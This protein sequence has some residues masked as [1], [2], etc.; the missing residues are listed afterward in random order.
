MAKRRRVRVGNPKTCVAYLRVST[1]TE[2]QALGVEAQRRAIQ[3]WADRAGVEIV[4][5]FT[6]EVSG[7]ASLDKR[8]ILLEAMASVA[9]HGA[10]FLVVHRLDR[11][12]REPLTAALA[13]IELKRHGAALACADGAGSG[14][15]PT[16]E[17]IRGILLSVHKFEKAM[18][19]ARIK[20]A[21]AVKKSRGELTGAAP[22][23]MRRA[24]D[25]K[26]LEPDEGEMAAIA[27]IRAL[28]ASGLTMR[29]VQATATKDGLRGRTGQPFTL[30]AIH[31]LL[32]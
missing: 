18:I 22:Y 29:G 23:G 10:G 27:H 30:A 17:L 21:L 2:K 24:P 4:G 1:D 7:G 5:W 31:A 20:G 6:E 25:G 12:S 26:L 3:I 32:H 11:F 14:D 16:S 19:R 28:R 13:E 15:D 9:A 8:P